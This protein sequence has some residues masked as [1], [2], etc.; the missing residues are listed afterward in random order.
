MYVAGVEGGATHSKLLMCN[1]AGA[2]IASIEGPGTNHWMLG[3][4]E[5]ARRIAKMVD[6]AKKAA[7]V[8]LDVKLKA[9]GLSLS[10]CEQEATNRELENELRV[11]HPTVSESYVVVSDTVGSILTA[12]NLGG[13]VLIS[14]TGSNAFLRNPSGSQ[15]QSGGWGHMLGDEGAAWWISHRAIKTVFDHEDNF[16]QCPYPLDRVWSL[17]RKHFDIETRFDL[18]PH[19][20]GEKFEKSFFAGLCKKLAEAAEQ[21]DELCIKIFADAG[22]ALGRFVL[23]LLPKVE[24][25]LVSSGSLCIVCV[26]SVWLSW[27]FLKGG[28]TKV[29]NS[30]NIPFEISLV[31]LT[32]SMG[33]G[34]CYMAA[35]SIKFEL[36]RDYSKNYEVFY[37]YTNNNNSKV[38]TN[39][40]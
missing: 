11:S 38:Q 9:L 4:P 29:L 19:C 15:A 10:G 17:I 12:S 40:N 8:P 24:A 7:G 3:I 39:G 28:F 31:K 35:D 14:G 26:G 5:C 22:Q 25:E 1:E 36:K 16:V 21:G 32:N 20:Y 13:L 30:T 18:L 23:A 37:T 33:L 2:I 34:A 27:K 6:D